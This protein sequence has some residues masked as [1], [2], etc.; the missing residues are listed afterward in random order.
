MPFYT[1]FVSP[2]KF[3]MIETPMTNIIKETRTNRIKINITTK[4]SDRQFHILIWLLIQSLPELKE[5]LYNKEQE[6]VNWSY[7][8]SVYNAIEKKFIKLEEN[9]ANK[10]RW[11]RYVVKG[12]KNIFFFLNKYAST[13]CSPE[14][15]LA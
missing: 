12:I 7:F 6:I 3:G 11:E 5:P 2:L 4:M 8:L 15:S 1:C 10:E 14:F 13:I 9:V